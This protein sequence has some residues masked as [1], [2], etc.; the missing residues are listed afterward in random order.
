M[1]DSVTKPRY[2]GVFDAYKQVWTEM[3]DP[4]KGMGWNN[5]ARLKN[6]Y[7]VSQTPNHLNPQKVWR[8]IEI[9]VPYPL[10]FVLSQLMPL[11]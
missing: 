10:Y 3:Y 6:F 7:R 4:K 9:R 2:N 5:L 8:L 1:T 11:L